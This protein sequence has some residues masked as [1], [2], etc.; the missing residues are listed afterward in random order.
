M[1][2]KALHIVTARLTISIWDMHRSW[3]VGVDIGAKKGEKMS[4]LKPCPFC[5]SIPQ[6]GT[7]FYESR[8][9]E[10][11]LAATV[12]CTG[13]GVRKRVI[14]KAS[15]PAAYVPFFDFDNAFDDVISKWNMRASDDESGI[16]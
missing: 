1:T 11:K 9:S 3:K 7:E 6:C 16:D 15:D 12:E 13:C 8:G 10:V 14:F 2:I 4:D 5:G